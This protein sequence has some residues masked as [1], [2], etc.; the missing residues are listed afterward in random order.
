MRESGHGILATPATQT[1]ELRSGS[2]DNGLVG[3]ESC[4]RKSWHIDPK[5]DN[6]F[7][8]Q[9]I[10]KSDRL[11]SLDNFKPAALKAR[12][13]PAA[14][15]TWNCSELRRRRGLGRHRMKFAT[16]VTPSLPDLASYAEFDTIARAFISRGKCRY[17]GRA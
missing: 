1:P 14:T 7:L 12:A 13:A 15:S 6:W 9:V 16:Q 8:L 4:C 11:I 2:Y 3:I 17:T 10:K 5:K